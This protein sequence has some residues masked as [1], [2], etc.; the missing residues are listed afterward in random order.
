M[1]NTKNPPFH[2]YAFLTDPSNLTLSLKAA[3]LTIAAAV[4]YFQDLH[5]IFN[6]ALNDEAAS[7]ILLVPVIFVYLIYRKRKM[8]RAAISA[9]NS[10]RTVKQSAL[11]SGILLCATAV[12]LYWQGSSTFTPLE[13]HIMTLPIFTA[14]L[15]LVLF[16]PQTL[17]QAIFPIVFLAFLTPPPSE[18][19]QRVGSALSVISTEAANAIVNLFGLRST[20]ISESGTP[21]IQIIR[22][23][24]T[25]MSFTVDI[26]CSGIYSLIG[27]VIFAA[28]IAYIVRDRIWKKITLLAIGFPLI[29]LLNIFRITL[30]VLI[31]YQWGTVAYDIFHLLGGWILI[32]LGTLIL[33][34]VAE[35]ALKTQIFAKKSSNT[36]P[37]CNKPAEKK[38]YCDT[39]GKLLKH[40]AI[41]FRASDA[42][43]IAAT[44]ITV[45]LLMSI[46]APVF[47][48][49][50][51]PAQI[52]IQTPTGQQGNTQILPLISGY[53]TQFLYRNTLFENESGQDVSLVYSY[54]PESQDKETVYVALEIAQTTGPLHRWEV[55]LITW[56]ETHGSQAYATQ[57]DLRDVTILQNPPI[58]ARYFAF[59]YKSDSQTQLVLYWYAS[60]ILTIN[61][62]TEQKQVKISLLTYPEN[63]DDI[64]RVEDQLL[65]IAATIAEYWQPIKTWTTVALT[66]SKNGIALA[67]TTTAFLAVTTAFYFFENRQKRKANTIA[68][69]KLSNTDQ[70]LVNTIRKMQKEK[71]L[72][73]LNKLQAAFQQET[74]QS[75]D[76]Q[77]LEQKLAEL[78]KIGIIKTIIANVQDEP[79]QTWKT[80]ITFPRKQ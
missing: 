71:T 51:G 34:A 28:F 67:E 73:T 10:Q 52:L 57:L 69:S 17:R 30:T 62:S 68:Y 39:C 35:K 80:Q 64:A 43:K 27:F 5:M 1:Q 22:P 47:A 79:A 3:T 24:N 49:T 53:T 77:Q 44:A 36:C 75:I 23:D 29:Y 74:G 76:V 21:A 37:D 33:L 12:I 8:L 26:A 11:I 25:S 20:I 14:G 40:S 31:G 18:I 13:Y 7:H 42:A 4:L 61:N 78:G 65:P 59:Q 46:Q 15:M 45:I 66:I 9:D 70:Q 58:V 38:A 50:Q 48:L 56:P 54:L 6:N 72:P 41:R 63:P 60:A 55:C 19:V 2:R 16:N 32:F